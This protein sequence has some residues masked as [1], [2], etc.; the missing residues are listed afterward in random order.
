MQSKHGYIS[1]D[2]PEAVRLEFEAAGLGNRALAWLIDVVIKYGVLFFILLVL[3]AI[4]AGM[5]ARLPGMS[6]GSKIIFGLGL[7][8]YQWFYFVLFEYYWCGQTPGKRLLRLRAIQTD[9]RC[10]A[11]W[12]SA[13]R[14]LARY[15]DLTGVGPILMALSP[16]CRRLGDYAAGTVV[17]KEQFGG[18]EDILSA[19]E[20]EA[21]EAAA[22]APVRLE[23][24]EY[25]TVAQFLRRRPQ[26]DQARRR[27]LAGELAEAMRLRMLAR[28]IKPPESK[29]D[30]AFLE[31]LVSPGGA[32][33]NTAD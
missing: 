24:Q 4:D 33:K 30:E 11:F 5:L 23:P 1:I 27:R 29:D 10:L 3:E 26:I 17:V 15:A 18:I 22:A 28:G 12:Q 16:S 13:V 31:M 2:T 7:F 32:Q 20:T 21:Q 19:I 25:E 6:Y 8:A 14:N 9:G